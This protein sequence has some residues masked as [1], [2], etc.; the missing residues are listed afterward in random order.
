MQSSEKELVYHKSRH[1]VDVG[2]VTHKLAVRVIIIGHAHLL[3]P[4][5]ERVYMPLSLARPMVRLS[6]HLLVGASVAADL[7]PM[8]VLIPTKAPV[9]W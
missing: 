4:R 7:V 1:W 9:A 2:I 6:A 3:F 8:G 5:P